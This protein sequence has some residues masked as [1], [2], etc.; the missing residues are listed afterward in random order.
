MRRGMKE[1]IFSGIGILIA[2]SCIVLPGEIV[3][4][5]A[6]RCKNEVI[7]TPAYNYYHGHST[8]TQMTLYERMKLIS[9]EWDSR[10][11]EVSLQDVHSMED[12]SDDISED[13]VSV[14]DGELQYPG[15]CY[16][17][18]QSVIERAEDG[19]ELLYAAGV[20]PESAVSEY[21]SWY[22]PRVRLYQYSDSIF[23]TYSCYVWLVQFDYYDGSM[24]HT[25]LIDDT[26]GL[27][28]AGGVRDGLDHSSIESSG[29]TGE[30]VVPGTFI[31]SIQDDMEQLSGSIISY[32]LKEVLDEKGSVDRER[33]LQLNGRIIS[34]DGMYT[35]N[36]D[37]FTA[38][39]WQTEDYSTVE[40]NPNNKKYLIVSDHEVADYEEAREEVRNI[41]DN[42]KYIF[43]IEWYSTEYYFKIVPFTV[44]LDQ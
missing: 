31:G 35:P 10:Y 34:K 23:N 25:L 32:Y 39:Y 28:L 7:Q 3:S 36:Y 18:F 8:A 43:E 41:V 29:S 40:E 11:Q 5:Q 19:L 44:K 13:F 4:Y 37:L 2:V 27:I 21:S 12:L 20:Y 38:A 22:R 33:L 17:D 9:G 30:Y 6:D 26:T 14:Q 15:Y 42:D 24:T 16:Q 1:W